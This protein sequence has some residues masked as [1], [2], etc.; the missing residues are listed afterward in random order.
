METTDGKIVSIGIVGNCLVIA[1]D[2]NKDG[3]PSIELK[4]DLLEVPDELVSLV[5]KKTV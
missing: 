5:R 2:S 3:Q 4:I 1:V